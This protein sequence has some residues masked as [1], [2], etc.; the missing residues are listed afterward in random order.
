MKRRKLILVRIFILLCL[1][2][3]V[4]IVF[5]IKRKYL[6]F[7]GMNHKSLLKLATIQPATNDLAVDT[8]SYMNSNTNESRESENIDA[9]MTVDGQPTIALMG[10]NGD[11]NNLQINAEQSLK[12]QAIQEV[13]Y[14][15][16]MRGEAIQYNSPKGLNAL[17]SPEE[18]TSQNMNHMV[19]SAFT[20]N[21]YHELLGIVL[22]T[23]S[24]K[25]IDYAK[26]YQETRKKEVIGYGTKD[27]NE[28]C[29]TM[30]FNDA[31]QTSTI[32]D[33]KQLLGHLQIRRCNCIFGTYM[34]GI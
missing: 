20:N 4:V 23:A 8:E 30:K 14:S 31:T 18:A 1:I 15:Y 24:D 25:L 26:T 10:Q 27:K 28:T 16:Y 21:V 19:C 13:A 3:S 9:I 22:P 34:Y 33:P 32:T 7:S 29:V 2:L 11:T 5:S 17:Y 12:N 6:N